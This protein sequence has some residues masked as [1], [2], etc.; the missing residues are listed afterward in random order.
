MSEETNDGGGKKK[1]PGKGLA[2]TGL[3]LGVVSLICVIVGVVSLKSSPGTAAVMFIPIMLFG[4]FGSILGII[5][6]IIGLVKKA[7][8][9]MV[10]W[11]G[12][13]MPIVS[14]VLYFAL[15]AAAMN[16]IM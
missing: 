5:G 7:D 16:S 14:I 8:S 2:K 4:W 6:L 13:L 15:I 12:A 1:T 9:K 11:L 10:H 3:I